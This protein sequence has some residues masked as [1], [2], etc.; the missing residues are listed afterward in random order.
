M[1][2]LRNYYILTLA[3]L[4]SACGFH[5]RGSASLPDDLKI[6]KVTAGSVPTA[7]LDVVK[8][9]L[10]AA[11]VTLDNNA[12]FE[13]RLHSEQQSRRTL[14]VNQNAKASEFELRSEL[15]YS[16]YHQEFLVLGP[17]SVSTVKSYEN[18]PNNIIGKREE[19]QLQILEMRQDL[20]RKL[21]YRLQALQPHILKQL[22]DEA[23]QQN[24]LID[25][26]P[27]K[28]LESPQAQP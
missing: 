12:E 21:M 22:C 10:V 1:S 24:T 5:L 6:M 16:L 14:S 23:A 13:L 18:D 7:T 11:S 8:N 25:I 4:I 3:L 2:K 26:A 27:K 17:A 15:H 19:E 20:V 9:A 28:S